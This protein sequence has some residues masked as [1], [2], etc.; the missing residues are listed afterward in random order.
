[1]QPQAGQTEGFIMVDNDFFWEVM[2][3]AAKIGEK[4]SFSAVQRVRPHDLSKMIETCKKPVE[5]PR[6]LVEL[7]ALH[8][9]S[10]GKRA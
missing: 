2:I 9:Q 7:A 10:H 1:M 3:V 6:R 4:G 5:P 8:R